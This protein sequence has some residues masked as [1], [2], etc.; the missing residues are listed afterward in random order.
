MNCHSY[1]LLRMMGLRE[2][3][4]GERIRKTLRSSNN[5]LAPFYCLRKDHKKIEEGQEIEGPKT[6]PLCGAS[7]CL[8][9]RTSYMLSK[10]LV[11]IIPKPNTQCNSTQELMSEINNLNK[12][13]IDKEWIICSLDVEALYPSLDM[14]EC[15]R[16]IEEQLNQSDFKIEGLKWTEIALYLRYHMTDEEIKELELDKFVP[17]RTTKIGRPPTFTSSGS[18][19]DKEK[20]LGPW[21]YKNTKPN[22]EIER[23]MFCRAI[24]IMIEKTMSL[25][26]Y[27]FDGDIIRQKSG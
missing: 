10:L 23:M 1:A 27:V 9:R 2:D 22:E 19:P 11:D 17:D 13:N 4:N 24:R 25:H 21:K 12:G 6:R 8:T 14:K 16:V 18:E 5:I 7:D 15:A 26:D 20:R 3:K